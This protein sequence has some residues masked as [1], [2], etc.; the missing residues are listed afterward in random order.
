[1]NY[2]T[3]VVGIFLVFVTGLWILKRKSYQGPKLEFI[4]G[5]ELPVMDMA[6]RGDQKE[7]ASSST[8]KHDDL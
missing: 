7:M 5:E 4:L 6:S 1:M 8:S 3:A 2:V